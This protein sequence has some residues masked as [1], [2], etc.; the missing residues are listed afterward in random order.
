MFYERLF[1]RDYVFEAML[2]HQLRDCGRLNYVLGLN[3]TVFDLSKIILFRSEYLFAILII[4][5]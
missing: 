3:S 5:F 2:A 1:C 4:L